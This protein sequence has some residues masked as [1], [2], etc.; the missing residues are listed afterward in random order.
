MD[1]EKLRKRLME[2]FLGELEDRLQSMSR[3]LLALEQK[4]STAS[5]RA[6]LIPSLLR[7]A[8]SLK[9][10]ARA[11]D[12]RLIEEACHRFEEILGTAQKEPEQLNADVF[13]LLFGT[14][15]GL[16][17]AKGR[18]RGDQ[19]LEGGLLEGI[20]LEM[21]MYIEHML[22]GARKADS[23]PSE[24]PPAPTPSD[25][26]EPPPE[27]ELDFAAAADAEPQQPDD[28]PEV[29]VSA[30]GGPASAEGLS[31]RID[32]EKLDLLLPRSGELLVAR[33]RL[34]ATAERLGALRDTVD[35]LHADWRLA[36]ALL[37]RLASSQPGAAGQA[38]PGRISE[39]CESTPARLSAL[40]AEL[41]QTQIAFTADWRLLDQAAVSLDEHVRR[42]RMLPFAHGCVGLDRL[43]R[44]LA[45]E[46]GKEAELQIEGG[47]VEIDRSILE[48]LKDPLRHLIRNAVDHGIE[49]PGERR[50][51]GKPPCGRI[52]ATAAV[53]GGQVVV[54]V[55]DD[56]RGLA[57]DAIRRRAKKMGLPVPEHERDIIQ[58]MFMP[59]F[60]TAADAVTM[61]S[62]R[63]IGL[64]AV[65]TQIKGLHGEVDVSFA[66]GQGTR[67][68]ISLPL[69]LTMLRA[70]LVT[71][72]RQIYAVSSAH[73]AKLLRIQPSDV[74][75]VGERPMITLNGKATPLLVLADVLRLPQSDKPG[76]HQPQ[77]QPR[78]H[79]QAAAKQ[80]VMVISIEDR[81][82]AFVVDE[83]L[84]EQEVM[85]KSLGSRIQR[86]PNI[87]GALILPSGQVALT[88]H[89]AD[90]V[91]SAGT[92]LHSSH[93]LPLHQP[94]TPE[95][96]RRARRILVVDDSVTTRS[97]EKSILEAAGFSVDVAKDGQEGWERVQAGDFDLVLSD[98]DMPRMIGYQ[99]IETI[100]RSERFRKL[101]VILI[102]SHDDTQSKER[103]MRAGASGY[104]V[105]GEFDQKVLLQL[106]EQLI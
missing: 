85:V 104:I 55:S 38:L 19:G 61:V 74:M 9:G 82:V 65:K 39:L 28:D 64:D 52:R 1:R 40:E 95:K 91:H 34:R 96:A 83:I 3:E 42:I 30:P 10:A 105:K 23:K 68:Q 89:V 59:G 80:P 73:V 33:Q 102:T 18:L 35:R 37:A 7:H 49:K 88:L 56:G 101:P 2:T 53:R 12:T 81:Q 86:I 41:E 84:A 26:A 76:Q 22:P 31:V 16:E 77:P 21:E 92:Q 97:L 66:P 58:V 67:F 6:R 87:A 54:T 14:I 62:G 44:D 72:S 48:G 63:G 79:G 11:V 27:G 99:M 20:S 15:D 8:H 75:V 29:P 47:E 90:L 46:S 78:S 13:Q 51:V 4:G 43:V 98:V 36:K 69:T 106:I 93:A 17:E 5:E 24:E 45:R 50:Q 60:S 71:V 70:L 100:R 94:E 103:A 25:D 57:V 32:T